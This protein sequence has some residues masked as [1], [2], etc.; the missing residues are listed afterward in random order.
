M[1][2]TTEELALRLSRLE[3]E[4]SRMRFA[5]LIRRA[6]HAPGLVEVLE[7]GKTLLNSPGYVHSLMSDWLDEVEAKLTN[8]G[9]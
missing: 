4:L 8:L 5:G 1:N 3:R 6:G 7:N 2:P 9:L